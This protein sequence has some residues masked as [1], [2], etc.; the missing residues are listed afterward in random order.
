MFVWLNHR[1][2]LICVMKK[3]ANLNAENATCETQVMVASE[4][5]KYNVVELLIQNKCDL[6]RPI[7]TKVIQRYILW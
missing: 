1:W 4:Y 6:N 2:L 3:G 7:N 5:G